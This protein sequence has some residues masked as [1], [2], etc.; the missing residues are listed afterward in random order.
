MARR[1]AEGCDPDDADGPARQHTVFDSILCRV[2]V[3]QDC[4]APIVT[5]SLTQSMT[6]APFARPSRSPR[7]RTRDWTEWPTATGS[8]GRPLEAAPRLC[9]N[10]SVRRNSAS[11][12]TEHSSLSSGRW[13]A[14][15]PSGKRRRGSST[16]GFQSALAHR[17]EIS[18]QQKHVRGN[19]RALFSAPRGGLTCWGVNAFG[20]V[21]VAKASGIV[22][23]VSATRV[24]PPGC[25]HA[26]AA[27]NR[28]VFPRR[29]HPANEFLKDCLARRPGLLVALALPVD[30]RFLGL[31]LVDVR[32]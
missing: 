21:R 19:R 2:V 17:S 11:Q 7:C 12:T 4:P 14:T 1:H 26:S 30:D 28:G 10:G 29:S 23:V 25:T 6:S 13:R 20:T 8:M 9:S 15:G 31:T 18:S 16:K 5:S 27:W 3:S 22:R 24:V 32:T